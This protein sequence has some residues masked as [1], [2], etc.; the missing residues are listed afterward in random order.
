MAYLVNMAPR[1]VELHRGLKPTGSLY[2]HAD[3]TMSHYLKVLLD[4]IFGPHCF[5]NEIIW[6]RSTAHS[7]AKQGSRHVGRLHDVLLILRQDAR[8]A[9]AQYTYSAVR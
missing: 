2:L 3:P 6:K 4:A 8:Q 1:L 9:N 5:V 7:D